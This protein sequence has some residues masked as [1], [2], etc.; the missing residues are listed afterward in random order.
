MIDFSS[1]VP[2]A[3]T[4]SGGVW[5]VIGVFAIGFAG[6]IFSY[7]TEK[8]TEIRFHA[9]GDERG[10][11]PGSF[12]VGNVGKDPTP[13]VRSWY[14]GTSPG[15]HRNVPV[16]RAAP[17]PKAGDQQLLARLEAWRSRLSSDGLGLSSPP[18]ASR[19]HMVG[20]PEAPLQLVEYADFEC[21]SCQAAL[22]VLERIRKRVGDELVLVVRHFP[23][24][25][26]HPMALVAAEAVEAA[27]AQGRFW[28][29][30][31]RIYGNRRPPTEDSLRRHAARLKLDVPRFE[32]ELRDHIHSRRVLE[33]F[34]SG[35]QSGVNGTPTFFVNGVRHDDE[36]TFNSLL[37][38]LEKARSHSASELL[39]T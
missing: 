7:F 33:D 37:G 13:D 9:W 29:M 27:G 10:D 25:D 18:D 14:R 2:L 8:G 38:A 31:R 34:D 17:A 11:A 21:P 12:G 6:I 3:Y 22:R 4:E 32:R 35:L 36:H 28:E 19:D 15:R 39:G 30:Y 26:A 20:P 1:T 24:L 16:Q 5:I 23:V